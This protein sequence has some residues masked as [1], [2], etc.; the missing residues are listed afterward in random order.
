MNIKYFLKVDLTTGT[1]W[2]LALI[3]VVVLALNLEKT[4]IKTKTKHVRQR[5]T[6]KLASVSAEG[7]FLTWK[8]KT[9]K[10]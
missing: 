3:Q 5:R 10:A 4:K 6:L 7:G 2:F 1:W 8:M 9:K